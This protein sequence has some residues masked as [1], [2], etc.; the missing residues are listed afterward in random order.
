MIGNLY[1]KSKEVCNRY[2]LK[3]NCE[4]GGPGYLLYNGPAEPLK[5]LGSFDILLG[6]FWINHSRFYKDGKDSIDILCVVKEAAAASHIKRRGRY[7]VEGGLPG[8]NFN[9]AAYLA[10]IVGFLIGYYTQQYFISLINGIVTAGILYYGWMKYAEVKNTN[11]ELQ[12]KKW[13]GIS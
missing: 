6:E 2:G 12:I 3:I 8:M 7:E 10:R 5:A 11:P 13:F 1:K 9:P 4:A